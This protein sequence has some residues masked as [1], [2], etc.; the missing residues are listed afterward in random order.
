MGS[1]LD[2]PCGA[3]IHQNLFAGTGVFRLIRDS[4]YDAIEEPV[5]RSKMEDLFFKAGT[6]V[7]RCGRCGRLAVEWDPQKEVVFYTPPEQ[8]IDKPLAGQETSPVEKPIPMQGIPII[9]RNPDP[10]RGFL[11]PAFIHHVEYHLTGLEVYSDG[12]IDCWGGVDL[13]IFRRKLAEG[14]VVTQPP[15]GSTISLHDLGT[16]TIAAAEW[17]ITPGELSAY[18]SVPEHQRHYCGNM[19]S[20]DWAI[21]QALYGETPP[22]PVDQE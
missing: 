16:A 2:C 3:K 10:V 14:W 13:G 11:L 5:D 9:R 19:D 6:P 20:K 18:E 1:W 8:A 7:F 4:D 22:G 21:R 17:R 15:V 12:V